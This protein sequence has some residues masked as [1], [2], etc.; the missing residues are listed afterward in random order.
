MISSTAAQS[1]MRLCC[2]VSE[3]PTLQLMCLQVIRKHKQLLKSYRDIPGLARTLNDKYF[4]VVPKEID[5]EQ[6]FI[7]IGTCKYLHISPKSYR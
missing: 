2:A 1:G 6:K 4:W 5:G 3:K 7:I